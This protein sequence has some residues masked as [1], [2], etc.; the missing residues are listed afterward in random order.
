MAS[1]ARFWSTPMTPRRRERRSRS[2]VPRRCGSSTSS[3]ATGTTTSSTPSITPAAVR[4][5]STRKPRAC[6]TTRRPA[7]SSPRAASTSPPASCGASGPSTAAKRTRAG[8]DRRDARARRLVAG[9]VARRHAHVTR[10]NGDR[11][12]RPR[13]GVRGGSRGPGRRGDDRDGVRGQ[14]RRRSLRARPAPRRPAWSIGVEDPARVGA[15]AGTPRDGARHATDRARVR[16]QDRADARRGRHQRRRAPLRDDG[17]DGGSATSSIRAPAGRSR[18]APARSRSW[19]G[20]ASRP[21]AWPPSPS[22][23]APTRRVSWSSRAW[24]SG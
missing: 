11:S 17:R 14:L 21:A 22:C 5:A 18:T 9:R 20:R 2:P 7:T 10:R 16:Y 8:G 19:P 12:R 1:R 6:S 24:S 4:S 23:A 15:T 3:A 13:Q